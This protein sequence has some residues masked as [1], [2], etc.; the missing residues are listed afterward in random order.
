M[1]LLFMFMRIFSVIFNWC[2]GID[3][4]LHPT[5]EQL[6]VFDD[7]KLFVRGYIGGEKKRVRIDHFKVD[8]DYTITLNGDPIRYIKNVKTDGFDSSKTYFLTTN[9]IVMEVPSIVTIVDVILDRKKTFKL[10]D[11]T[12][13]DY[14]R[15]IDEMDE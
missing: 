7:D 8:G 6:F 5:P 15:L 3:K 1:D 9:N 11:R 10:L 14:I 4:F 2:L 13:I 12:P